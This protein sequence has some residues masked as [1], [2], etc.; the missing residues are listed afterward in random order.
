MINKNK[1]MRIRIID[2]LLSRKLYPSKREIIETIEDK[3][4]E[5][6]GEDRNITISPSS[7]D[8]DFKDMRYNNAMFPVTAEIKYDKNEKGYFY[9]E[10][11]GFSILKNSLTPE[12]KADIEILLAYFKDS[13][14]FDHMRENIDSILATIK[15][16]E[17]D[18]K[19][20]I[21]FDRPT[22]YE[23]SKYLP[24]LT[25]CIKEKHRVKLK[26]NKTF[27]GNI[28]SKIIDP[29]FLKEFEKRWYL[30]AY[31]NDDKGV[32][33]Y[34]LSRIIELEILD[35]TFIV[36]DDLFNPDEYYK[37]IYGVFA[38]PN[39]KIQEFILQFDKEEGMLI[40]TLKI[41]SSQEK[42]KETDKHIT[43][44]YSLQ[45]NE[46]SFEMVRFISKFANNVKV[47]KPESLKEKVLS[48]L[49]KAVSQYKN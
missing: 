12:Q 36:F 30:I 31:S 15:T 28:S 47:I 8:K 38:A 18:Q 11:P 3:F 42:I 16:S 49:E 34:E 22:Y 44:K 43:F 45:Y 23:G 4:K 39:S 21:Q 5:L 24:I 25:K 13:P 2:N 32:R 7:I 29:Y 41:H 40:D 35:E 10:E 20:I 19:K 46:N 9:D 6:Y 37:N 17:T 26:Y 48:R 14:L 1:L 33:V 27:S